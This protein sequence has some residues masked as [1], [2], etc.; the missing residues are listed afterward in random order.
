MLEPSDLPPQTQV[1][2]GRRQ[3]TRTPPPTLD[4]GTEPG[5]YCKGKRGGEERGGE[6]GREGFN[7]LMLSCSSP[8]NGTES[9]KECSKN[10]TVTGQ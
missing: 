9:K 5:E 3:K 2:G 7:Q 1:S 8:K 6:R 4:H 10:E